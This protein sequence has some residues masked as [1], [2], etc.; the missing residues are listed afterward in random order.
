[1]NETVPSVTVVI[2]ARPAQAEVK[3]VAASRALDY[4]ADRLEIVVARGTQPS[5]QRNA[6]LRAAHGDLIYFLDDDSAPEP[7]NVRRAVERF[8]DPQVQMVGG[9]NVCPSDAPPLEQVF[10]RVL[11]SWLAF[12]PSRARYAAVGQVRETS[13]K[14]LILC[15]L[16]ARRET[17]L[18]LGGFDEALYPNE[19]NAL[20]DGL[21]RRGGK[22]LYDPQLVVRR[23]PR[24]S[25]R[26]FARMLM[27]Y[28]R[29]RAEQFRLHPTFG[30]ALN[31]V[32][33]LFCLYLLALLP[34]LTLTPLGKSCLLP[35]A[36]YILAVLAQGVSLAAGGQ[37]WQSIAAIPLIVLT[38]L[39]YGFG[40]WRGLFTR[41]KPPG[42]PAPTEVK[43]ETIPR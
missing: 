4:P 7:G 39:L 8:R 33:P 27:T 1:M 6:A 21:Q 43:V 12:G 15:N 35:L 9:P 25:L 42:Q 41:L 23:R 34:L 20:M 14:E 26:S 3:A 10:A 19:E 5:V 30:S 36:F 24:S 29:G 40:F 2:A 28:G 31:F 13:E 38:H 37:V 17:M 22:L 16:L 32:P 11:A 18:E